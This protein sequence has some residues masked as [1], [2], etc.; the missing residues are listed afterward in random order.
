MTSLCCGQRQGDVYVSLVKRKRLQ[1][2]E[3]KGRAQKID[4]NLETAMQL[5]SAA[6]D[7][8]ADEEGESDAVAQL[9]KV[10]QILWHWLEA[11]GS[12]R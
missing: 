10:N 2:L 9:T 11:H 8:I 5:I 12:L 3:A 1:E 7:V 6:Q 4:S